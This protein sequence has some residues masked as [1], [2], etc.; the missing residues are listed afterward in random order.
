MHRIKDDEQNIS[1]R[2]ADDMLTR[3]HF[4]KFKEDK[5]KLIYIRQYH[6]N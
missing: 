3:N 1:S 6:R 5:E 2:G 4:Y